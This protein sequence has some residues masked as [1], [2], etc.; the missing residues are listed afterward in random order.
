MDAADKLINYPDLNTINLSLYRSR[1][2][3]C[4]VLTKDNQIL[5][6]QR[7]HDWTR[8]P[9]YLCEFGG[10]IEAHETPDQALARE[11]REELG[12]KNGLANVIKIGA[13]SELSSKHTE[14]IYVYFWHDT[15]GMITG[16]YEG[17]PRYFANLDE[18]FKHP[19]MMDSVRWLLLECQRRGFITERI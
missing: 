13:I 2:V 15:D 11:L 3:G 6:Q 1:Y 10:Q 17:E 5:L 16:C 12:V 8:Y 18:V 4:V 9:G 14:L 19:K 7:G